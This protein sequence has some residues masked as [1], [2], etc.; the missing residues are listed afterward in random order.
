MIR[1]LSLFLLI[2]PAVAADIV[3]PAR[4]IPAQSLI[5]AE[6]LLLRDISVPGSISDPTL[7]IGKEARIALFAGRPIRLGDIGTPAIVARNA[8]IT[9][10][11]DN[12]GLIIR[13]EGRALDRAGPGELIRVMNLAS[14]STVTA[15]ISDDGNAYVMQ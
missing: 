12:G 7:I 10:I 4:T 6:D 11:Y 5:S 9:L 8:I 1:L 15:R 14:R 3:V 2:A 13:T